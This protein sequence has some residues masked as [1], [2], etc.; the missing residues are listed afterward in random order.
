MASF[1]SFILFS[2]FNG[3]QTSARYFNEIFIRKMFFFF[4]H[5]V[6]ARTVPLSF[7]V[8]FEVQLTWNKTH[9]RRSKKRPET[10]RA[11]KGA[12]KEKSSL[13]LVVFICGVGWIL[14]FPPWLELARCRPTTPVTWLDQ[15][16]ISNQR[17]I[18]GRISHNILPRMRHSNWVRRIQSIWH[19][20]TR[21]EFSF[22]ECLCFIP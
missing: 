9:S 22:T 8:I 19:I 13:L 6:D 12:V 18:P 10:K 4:F 7:K 20:H 16:K 5:S 14:V 11:E 15:K 17:F 3:P 1:S 21:G 2:Q